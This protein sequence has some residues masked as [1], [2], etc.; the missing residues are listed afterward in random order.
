[1]HDGLRAVAQNQSCITKDL[2]VKPSSEPVRCCQALVISLFTL[3][4]FSIFILKFPT[5]QLEPYFDDT[6]INFGSF[7]VINIHLSLEYIPLQH[8]NI[9]STCRPAILAVYLCKQGFTWISNF[10]PCHFSYTWILLR[11]FQW[12]NSLILAGL[13]PVAATGQ[14]LVGETITPST[15]DC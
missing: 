11:V 9:F 8:I 12:K 5:D 7:I 15:A 13:L 6:F 14:L 3:H 10:P 2:T 1:M 4:F